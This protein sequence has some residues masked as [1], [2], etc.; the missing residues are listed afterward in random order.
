MVA[1]VVPPVRV[2]AAV[3]AALIIALFIWYTTDPIQVDP[4]TIEPA[5]MPTTIPELERRAE[6]LDAEAAT[7][8]MEAAVARH[9]Y[10]G[11]VMLRT[12]AP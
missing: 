6:R 8:R 2:A 4:P 5:P 3:A 1:L 10:R 9:E 11:T 7:A 12:A